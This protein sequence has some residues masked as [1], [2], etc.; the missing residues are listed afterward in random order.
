MSAYYYEVYEVWFDNF[1][2]PDT[3][4]TLYGRYPDYETANTIAH[5]LARKAKTSGRINNWPLDKSM[6]DSEIILWAELYDE[7]EDHIKQY[8]I[9]IEE[10]KF[11]RWRG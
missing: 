1:K 5:K 4:R 6:M 8:A 7:K 11:D 3:I 2:D 9:F 10:K